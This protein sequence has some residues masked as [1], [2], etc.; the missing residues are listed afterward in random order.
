MFEFLRSRQWIL[1][2]RLVLLG[3]VLIL[4]IH[5]YGGT[6][7]GMLQ[8]PD[9]ARDVQ[10]THSEFRTDVAGDRPVWIIH[11][12]NASR[13]FTYDNLQMEASYFDNQGTQVDKDHWVVHQKLGPGQDITIGSAD[14]KMRGTAVNGTLKVVGATQVK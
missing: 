8:R 5:N 11:F 13:R 2:R 4:A 14:I 10:I 12:Q 7:W 9:A 3:I 1:A 6:V